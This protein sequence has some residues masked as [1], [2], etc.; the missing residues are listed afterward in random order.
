MRAPVLPARRVVMRRQMYAGGEPCDVT[1]EPRQTEVRFGCG[2]AAGRDVLSGLR[3]PATC[4][5]VLHLSTPRLCGHAAFRVAEP[6]VR[7][8]LCSPLDAGAH[9]PVAEAAGG[10][11]EAGA[12]GL[13][14]QPLVAGES[15]VAWEAAKL[16]E[17]PAGTAAGSGQD[18]EQVALMEEERAEAEAL[19][20]EGGGAAQEEEQPAALHSKMIREL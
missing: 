5:Y 17:G 2:E 3:E 16:A 6:P 4:R 15:G 19:R 1:G 20:R 8:I 13:Q 18:S 10:D 14:P 9:G 11:A 7:A 12:E